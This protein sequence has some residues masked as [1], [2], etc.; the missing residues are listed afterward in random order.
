MPDLGLSEPGFIFTP[1]E[2]RLPIVVAQHLIVMAD[3]DSIR[4][5]MKQHPS[6]VSLRSELNIGLTFA[7]LA[8]ST[9][10]PQ[11]R[12]SFV[13]NAIA[14]YAAVRT[15]MGGIA[16]NKMQADDLTWNMKVL[17]QKLAKLGQSVPLP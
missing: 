17:R 6:L 10:N 12:L 14:A 11:K 7:N 16:V 15:V 1:A 4:E 2:R 3:L 8:L 13:K 9:D 5:T